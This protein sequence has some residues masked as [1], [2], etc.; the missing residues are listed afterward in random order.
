MTASQPSSQ[1]F[2]QAQSS[3]LKR[4]TQKTTDITNATSSF[5]SPNQFAVLSDTETE[6]EELNYHPQTRDQPRIPPIVIYSFLANHSIPQKVNNKLPAH[7]EVK[8]KSNRFL[9]YTKSTKDYNT[10]LSEIQAATLEYH[11]YPLSDTRQTSTKRNPPECT[12][13]RDP[14]S[15]RQTLKIYQITKTDKSTTE[16]L[17]RYPVF[18]ATFSRGTDVREVLQISKLC[19]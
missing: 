9:L 18:V 2:K 15:P 11:T 10:V 5:L 13:R 16:V 7:V 4:D 1:A 19:H 3:K 8:T 12:R 17:T 6:T 14:C